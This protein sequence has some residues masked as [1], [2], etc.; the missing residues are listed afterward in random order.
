MATIEPGSKIYTD[1]WK[2]YNNLSRN[3]YI[4]NTV[5][6][7]TNFVNILPTGEKMTQIWKLGSIEEI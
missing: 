6:H 1:E 3:G 7:T 2:S 4:H 5:N